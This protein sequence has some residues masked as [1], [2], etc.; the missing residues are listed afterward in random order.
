MR[1]IR[2]RPHEDLEV[3]YIKG[4]FESLSK[5]VGGVLQGT[6]PF[7]GPYSL[8]CND[9]DK[10][11]GLEPNIALVRDCDLVDIV[12]GTILIVR[13]GDEDYVSITDEDVKI[14][15]RL[16]NCRNHFCLFKGDLLPTL[17]LV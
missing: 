11:E 15:S 5:E 2:K 16:I 1:V 7:K 3:I 10:S 8:L 4:D 13:L 9:N 12:V 6:Y 17:E 14:I